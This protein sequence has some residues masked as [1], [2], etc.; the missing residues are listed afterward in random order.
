MRQADIMWYPSGPKFFFQRVNT[1]YGN[2]MFL[3]VAI[4]KLVYNWC[5]TY[6]IKK[7]TLLWM[8]AKFKTRWLMYSFLARQC[9][10]F[11]LLFHDFKNR[12][13]VPPKNWWLQAWK[14]IL[15]LRINCM[16]Y[17]ILIVLNHQYE[18]Y[19]HLAVPPNRPQPSLVYL[20]IKYSNI[21]FYTCYILL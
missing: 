15:F 4:L 16:I 3:W 20:S 19:N 6:P 1:T 12:L 21:F 13:V 14:L 11:I 17:Q 2:H 18:T 5:H 10:Q 7:Y 9:I 8:F